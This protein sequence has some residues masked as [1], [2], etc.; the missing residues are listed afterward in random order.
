MSRPPD[1]PLSHCELLVVSNDYTTLRTFARVCQ[2]LGARIESAPSIAAAGDIV[3]KRKVDGIV[4]DMRMTG[5]FD[6][7]E[8]IRSGS[9]NRSAVVLACCESYDESE[10][11]VNAGANLLI[12]KPVDEDNLIRLLQ[13]SAPM[14]DEERRRYFRHSVVVPVTLSRD[15]MTQNV[16]SSNM[17][18]TGMAIRSLRAYESGTSVEF[19][20][21]LPAGPNVKGR[22]QIMWIDSQ[23]RIGIKFLF[24]CC[25][26]DLPLSEWLDRNCAVRM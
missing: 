3:K 6:L 12:Q 5:A 13:A 10:L 2:D 26:G 20:F 14:L 8:E 16:L 1:L 4:V 25:S 19:D 15:G 22:G 24:L 23:G 17:S 9:S 18:Q 21:T 11:A 7:I